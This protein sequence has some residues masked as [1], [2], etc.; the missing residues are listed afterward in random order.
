MNDLRIR[1][2]HLGEVKLGSYRLRGWIKTHRRSKKIAFIELTDGSC[3]KGLQLVVDPNL[4][5]YQEIEDLLHTGSSIEVAGELVD[6]PAKGQ[7]FEFQVGEITLHGS[8]DPESYP[9]QKK[10]HSLEFLREHLHLRSRSNTLGAVFRVRSRAAFAIHK[11]FQDQGYLYVH[12]PIITT[13]DCEGAGEMFRVTTFDPAKPALVDNKVDYSQDFFKD[14]AHLTVSGQL[15]A[16]IFA[17]SHMN[18]YTFGP[19]FRSENSNTTRHL[20]EFWMIEPEM[21]FCD[22]K[23]NMQIGA[24]FI[25]YVISDV[26]N[27][28]HD[29]LEFLAER[30]WVDYPLLEMLTSLTSSEVATLEYTEAIKILE[31]SGQNFEFPVAW[32]MDLQSEHEKFLTD[33][34]I[35]GPCYII[36]YPKEIK[37][38]YMRLNDDEKTVAAMDLLVPRLGEIIGGSQREERLDKLESRMAEMEIP[39]D[40]LQWYLELRK[41]GGVEHSGFGLGFE[42]LLMYLTGINNIRDVTPF[43]RFPGY[44]KF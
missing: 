20:A 43:P 14:Q 38:F 4:Q 11:F 29:D 31:N 17:L 8:A 40:N 21:A 6:S 42:R 2:I 23:G 7:A 9:L 19:T 41:Y 26:L 12:T 28:C 25:K 18:C 35:S 3:V 44:A 33:Q 34:Y 27:Y 10:K 22:L 24:E 5:G 32:G 13:S 16:E 39:S 1:H 36:N 30:E 37:A 15:E